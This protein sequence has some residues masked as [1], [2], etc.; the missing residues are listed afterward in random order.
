MVSQVL[1]PLQTSWRP[2]SRPYGVD[3]GSREDSLG[4]SRQGSHCPTVRPLMRVFDSQT[5]A[6]G[7]KQHLL[8]EWYAMQTARE[9]FPHLFAKAYAMQL[10]L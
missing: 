2:H 5:A 1:P 7:D 8:L 9:K 6:L 3:L 4:Q 10:F